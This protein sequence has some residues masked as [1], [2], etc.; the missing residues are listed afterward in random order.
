MQ[1]APTSP[2]PGVI[3]EIV[4][5]RPFEKSNV[6]PIGGTTQWWSNLQQTPKIPNDQMPHY[7]GKISVQIGP[8]SPTNPLVA[9]PR[10]GVASGA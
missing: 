4:G 10:R 5:I 9:K 7:R 6:P 1:L 8:K 2:L 3:G